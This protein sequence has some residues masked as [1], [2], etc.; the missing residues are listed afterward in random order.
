MSNYNYFIDKDRR[1]LQAKEHTEKVGL[2]YHNNT[3]NSIL[4]SIILT[5]NHTQIDRIELQDQLH[6]ISINNHNP[7]GRITLIDTDSVSAIFNAYNNNLYPIILNFASYKNPGGMFMN[8]SSAQEESLCHRS[9][10]YNILASRELEQDYNY[11]RSHLNNGLYTNRAVY[12][13]RVLF[14]EDQECLSYKEADVITCAAPNKSL[15]KYGRFNN[16]DNSKVLQDRI[17]FIT[18]ICMNKIIEEIK[19][20]FNRQLVFILGAY[21]CGV[22][23]QDPYEVA[24]VYRK[25]IENYIV[26]YSNVIFAIPGGKNYNAFK[27]VFNI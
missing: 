7:A 1:A 23:R 5:S 17:L 25:S 21:G 24:T 10:L 16:Y 9:N 3:V 19:S 4:D 18:N 14:F 15:I 11:N 26:P 12:T 8:G 27:E 13:P 6:S 22:F 20:G 2:Y